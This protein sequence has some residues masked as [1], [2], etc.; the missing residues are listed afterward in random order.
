[1]N[2][3]GVEGFGAEEEQVHL[4]EG[5]EEPEIGDAKDGEPEGAVAEQVA[6][7]SGDFGGGI[8]TERLAGACGGFVEVIILTASRAR[9]KSSP[10]PC[11][12]T[13]P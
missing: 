8:P 2:V 11:K 9:V 6:R 10:S 13:R 4:E 5:A 7:A 1:M 3:V 12:E